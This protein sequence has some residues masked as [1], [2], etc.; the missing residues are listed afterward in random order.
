MPAEIRGAD[1]P[2]R[3]IEMAAPPVLTWQLRQGAPTFYDFDT[4]FGIKGVA[5]H[6]DR[7]TAAGPAVINTGM[8]PDDTMPT[9]K[10]RYLLG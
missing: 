10:E 6:V 1:S 2:M 5:D 3:R 7:T 8:P 9:L 4:L